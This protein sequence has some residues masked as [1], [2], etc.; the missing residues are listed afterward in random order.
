MNTSNIDKIIPS[1][2]ERGIDG[3]TDGAVNFSQLQ[4]LE[5]S[6]VSVVQSSTAQSSEARSSGV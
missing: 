4:S 3:R 6:M 2:T 5:S 1:A